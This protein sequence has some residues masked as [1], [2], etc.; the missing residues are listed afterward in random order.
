MFCLVKNTQKFIKQQPEELRSRTSV[1]T[2]SCQDCFPTQFNM[3]SILT[4]CAC[5]HGAF[6][7]AEE[8]LEHHDLT[9]ANYKQEDSFSNGPVSDTLQNMFRLQS[10]VS[11]S[12]SVPS[13]WFSRHLQDFMNG[14]TAW[15]QLCKCFVVN[16]VWEQRLLFT[17]AEI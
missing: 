4:S 5:Y 17:M 8:R 16:Q 6:L 10:I 11:L 15:L 12:E 3:N 1:F 2:L 14:H 13:L 7:F 9:D